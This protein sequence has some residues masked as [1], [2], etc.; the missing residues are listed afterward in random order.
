VKISGVHCASFTFSPVF[1]PAPQAFLP[2]CVEMPFSAFL[3]IVR[4]VNLPVSIG[5]ILRKSVP[6][7]SSCRCPRAILGRI[8]QIPLQKLSKTCAKYK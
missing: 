1:H 5:K 3:S 7:L 4:P 8:K 2:A 6:I